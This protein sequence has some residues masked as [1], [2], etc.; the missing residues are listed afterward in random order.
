[1]GGRS[2][3]LALGLALYAGHALGTVRAV[4]F[5]GEV[6][7]GWALAEPPRVLA[8]WGEPPEVAAL[9]PLEAR[10][11]R[12]L[13][14]LRLGPVVMPL[15][16]NTYTGGLADWPA[17][18][19][20]LLGGRAAGVGVHLL[21]GALL[22]A[23]AHRFLRFHGT[24]TAAGAVAL[25]LGTDWCFVFFKRVLGG[26]EILLQAAGL[27][28]LWSLWSRRWKGGR[29]GTVAMALGVGLGLAAKLTFVPTLLALGLAAVATRWDRPLVNPPAPVRAWILVALPAVCLSPLLVANLHHAAL[30]VPVR[31]HDVLGL[32]FERLL[33]GGHMGRE[34]LVNLL[35]F[36]GNPLD[37]L[38]SAWGTVSTGALDPLRVASL[39]VAV[40][41]AALEWRDPTRSPSA[42]LLRFLSVFV[43][44][45]VVLLF[46][47]NRDL[48]HLAQA[49]VPLACLCA[50]GA[51]RLAAT[52]YPPR[53]WLRA[54]A[55]AILVLPLCWSGSAQLRA[56][57]AVVGTARA[58]LFR[59]T[60]QDALFAMCREHGVQ[61]VVTTSY[62]A[63]GLLE[64][65]LPGV[66]VTHAWGAVAAGERD[67]EALQDLASGGHYLRL[68]GSAPFVYDWRPEG[69]G[70]PVAQLSD[71]KQ[72]WAEL[73][74]IE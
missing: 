45:Q 73:F 24:P 33:D 22:L 62:E 43:P 11:T 13:E 35:R 58:A 68:R 27:L 2:V 44:V 59:A 26:T 48:H 53:S 42:A 36:F 7:I 52:L 65:G 67:L 70:E 1:M 40:V 64:Q 41:G 57:D 49:T 71:G 8:S 47:A 60:G 14:V 30:A 29:H 16:V 9:G 21:L 51:D 10:A 50:L 69:L 18:L 63:Y 23:L 5:V 28:V 66:L 37:W 20:T 12:P 74:A 32:Q 56:T 39:M 34:A 6:D 3:A 31:S 72:V 61:R 15:A 46:L 17:R 38:S 55:T 25:L 19:A 4:G 54:L